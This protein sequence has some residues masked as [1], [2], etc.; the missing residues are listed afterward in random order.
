MHP[1]AEICRMRL[2]TDSSS[3]PCSFVAG[4]VAHSHV[5]N[6]LTRGK[7]PSSVERE[8]VQYNLRGGHMSVTGFLSDLRIAGLCLPTGLSLPI[9]PITQLSP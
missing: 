4:A 8:L 1:D 9:G 2:S 7:G 3:S 5:G 6:D